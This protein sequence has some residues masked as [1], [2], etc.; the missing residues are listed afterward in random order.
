MTDEGARLWHTQ[1]K[2][3]L[4]ALIARAKS[5]DALDRLHQQAGHELDN[6]LRRQ[7]QQRMTALKAE[8]Q[9]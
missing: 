4:A 8:G 5:L 9:R 2:A 1:R 6:D 7:L 3:D